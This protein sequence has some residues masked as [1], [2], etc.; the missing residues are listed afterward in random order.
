M[1]TV[2][3]HNHNGVDSEKLEA[4]NSLINCPQNSVTKPTGGA[5]VDSQARAAISDLIDKLQAVGIIK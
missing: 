1:D 2:I 5:T 4:K 3:R